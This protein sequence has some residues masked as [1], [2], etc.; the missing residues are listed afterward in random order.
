MRITSSVGKIVGTSCKSNLLH[1]TPRNNV[2]LYMELASD[3][4]A[5]QRKNRA[6]DVIDLRVGSCNTPDSA[7]W[8]A[9]S[10]PCVR[11]AN[12][13]SQRKLGFVLI[14]FLRYL[15]CQLACSYSETTMKIL[16][17]I[18]AHKEAV[19]ALR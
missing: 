9:A 4:C 6:S 11:E 5:F 19:R 16:K 7:I 12:L 1:K 3:G 15:S 14:W 17:S 10:L 8:L 18:P 13:F 2:V